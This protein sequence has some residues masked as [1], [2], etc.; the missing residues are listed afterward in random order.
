[1]PSANVNDN[2]LNAKY[3]L[4]CKSSN[5]A[6]GSLKYYMTNIE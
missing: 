4:W 1:M 6:D 3:A 5:V 2:T